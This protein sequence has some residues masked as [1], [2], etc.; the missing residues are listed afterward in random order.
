MCIR[1]RNRGY[2]GLVKRT[3]IERNDDYIINSVD[4]PCVVMSTVA[5]DD[6]LVEKKY[7]PGDRIS[8]LITADYY[9]D[10]I[11]NYLTVTK[12][13]KGDWIKNTKVDR[14]NDKIIM[15]N[16]P[17]NYYYGLMDEVD[18]KGHYIKKCN[19]MNLNKNENCY[20]NIRLIFDDGG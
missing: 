15:G 18:L 20:V 16:D 6:Y 7:L 13:T 2:E 17:I 1:D 14:L 8:V 4:L 9:D 11:I 19:I 5:N 12:N 3:N 10:E